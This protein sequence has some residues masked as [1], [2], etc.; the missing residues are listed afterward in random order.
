[1]SMRKNALD[2]KVYAKL[3][4]KKH[5]FAKFLRHFVKRNWVNFVDEENLRLCT[6]EFAE[7]LSETDPVVIYRAKFYG[8]EIFLYL[9]L[10]D[11]PVYSVPFRIMEDMNAILTSAFFDAPKEERNSADFRLPPVIPIVFYNG[12]ESWQVPHNFKSYFPNNDDFDGL[13]DF[14]YILVDVNKLNEE[15]LLTHPD[16]ICAT[17]AA[18]KSRNWSVDG[19]P[20]D[21]TK[22]AVKLA[23]AL[24]GAGVSIK[25]VAE[26]FNV[27]MV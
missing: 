9:L 10:Q 1:M 2:N 23:L 14:E 20:E 7:R 17:I 18:D 3:L 6:A 11:A 8:E 25:S 21:T 27:E 13:L 5:H 16:T 24:I 22:D 19:F 4:S 15:Y 12:C 26:L